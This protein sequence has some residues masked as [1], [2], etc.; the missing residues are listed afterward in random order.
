[1]Y[2]PYPHFY[3]NVVQNQVR[4]V[5]WRGTIT[6]DG[7]TYFFEAKHIVA[8]SGQIIN[9]IAGSKMEI[10]TAYASELDISLYIDDIGVPRDKIYGAK[11]AIKCT[12][13]ANGTEATIPMGVFNVVEATQK[14]DVC[15]IVAYDNMVLL[16]VE[17]PVSQGRLT[18]YGWL[19]QWGE[20]CGFSLG[21]MEAQVRSLP[22][23][24]YGLT[25]NWMDD[26]ST[27]RDALSQLAA[28][29][30]CSAHF[31]RL[32]NLVLMPLTN[33]VSVATLRANDR[34]GSDISH[35][36][37]SPSCFYV[38]NAESGDITSAGSG[39][40]AFDLGENAFLQW[41]GYIYNPAYE[42]PQIN[43]PVQRLV[44]NIYYN[45]NALTV[46]PVDAEIP[47]DPCLDLF[48]II[49]L[50][51]GQANN[52]K[53]LITSITHTIGGGT[54]INCAGSNVTEESSTPAVGGSGK[55]S[56]VWIDG[57]T[58]DVPLQIPTSEEDWGDQKHKT[59]TTVRESTWDELINGGGW[60]PLPYH[61]Y[62]ADGFQRVFRPEYTFGVI[63]LTV[64]YTC[65]ATIDVRF[66]VEVSLFAGG[67]FLPVVEF[68]SVQH[69]K[70]GT[71]T[72]TINVPFGILDRIGGHYYF[73]AYIS[74]IEE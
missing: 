69:A 37:W 40:L 31:N 24:I 65:D 45:S 42:P 56:E 34:Y 64:E 63:G 70:E 10:G 2:E 62:E 22:N 20:E 17:F 71:H 41:P 30:G 39:Q 6:A 48:D 29:T 12:M 47:L 9:E 1:M 74:G 46:V 7:K 35:T 33:S 49:T 55:D 28:A 21:Q 59:W 23:G 18:P 36:Q 61:A 13:K 57:T 27:Y 44:Q 72:T 5:E 8:R 26:K 4:N 19:K 43:F 16:D 52:T 32:G 14:G 53:T 60:V 3:S 50:T 67:M 54:K 11:I 58:N 66:R 51:G 15:T 68:D 25:M 73:N 38:R